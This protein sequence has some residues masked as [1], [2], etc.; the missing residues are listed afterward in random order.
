M[1]KPKCLIL[2]P[3]IYSL[4]I[5]TGSL[6][7]TDLSVSIDQMF[8]DIREMHRT[9]EEMHNE[10]GNM[11]QTVNNLFDE[12]VAE[13]FK[14]ETGEKDLQTPLDL[15]IDQDNDMVKVT[16]KGIVEDNLE[17]TITDNFLTIKTPEITIHIKSKDGMLSVIALREEKKETKEEKNSKESYRVSRT[18]IAHYLQQA[19][20][21]EKTTVDYN[22]EN[23]TVIATIPIITKKKI[24]PINLLK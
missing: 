1:N 19:L 7:R 8:E 23:Q 4:L 24:I 21:L 15:A 18:Q 17:A 5:P 2:S 9:M 16:C 13:S 6:C 3:L 10:M 22:K 12:T 20:D 14:R 11:L